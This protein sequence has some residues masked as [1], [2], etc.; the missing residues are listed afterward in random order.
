[1]WLLPEPR[2]HAVSFCV[3]ELGAS[4]CIRFGHRSAHLGPSCCEWDLG[5]R[6]AAFVRNL[7]PTCIE[8]NSALSAK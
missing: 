6:F 4:L 7:A 8:C 5:A 1:M 3:S 2:N